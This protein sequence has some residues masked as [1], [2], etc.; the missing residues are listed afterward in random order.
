MATHQEIINQLWAGETQDSNPGLLD[1]DA[2]IGL[3]AKACAGIRQQGQ[4]RKE[5]TA[6]KGQL[7][8]DRYNRQSEWDI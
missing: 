4:K 3:P 7:E 5:R 1:R 2:R 8:P 6:R